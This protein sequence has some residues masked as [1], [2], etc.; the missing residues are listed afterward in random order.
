MVITQ[1]LLHVRELREGTTG[2]TEGRAGPGEWGKRWRHALMWWRM[3]W[4]G[5]AASHVSEMAT[6]VEDMA[7]CVAVVEG[8][9]GW[10]GLYGRLEEGAGEIYCIN[11]FTDE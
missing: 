6:C 7:T 1:S 10:D 11:L 3:G 5:W 8:W 9:D 2:G 4:L